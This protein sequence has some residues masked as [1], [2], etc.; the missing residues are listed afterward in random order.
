MPFGQIPFVFLSREKFYFLARLY[1]PKTKCTFKTRNNYANQFK[2]NSNLAV[3]KVL[4]HRPPAKLKDIFPSHLHFE[5][6]VSLSFDAIKAASTYL[7][8]LKLVNNYNY[9]STPFLRRAIHRYGQ[10]FKLAQR[11]YEKYGL[12]HL[13]SLVPT[14]D[15][16]FIWATHMIHPHQY[17]QWRKQFFDGSEGKK[18]AINTWFSN[19]TMRIQQHAASDIHVNK[20]KERYEFT[21]REWEKMYDDNYLLSNSISN[22][23]DSFLAVY[24]QGT[25]DLSEETGL[26]LLEA[27]KRHLR[28][29]KRTLNLKFINNSFLEQ[30]TERYKNFLLMAK[31]YNGLL[32]PTLDIDII[33]HTHMLSPIDYFPDCERIAGR[34]LNHNDELP[35]D[36]LTDHFQKTEE[37][38]IRNYSSPYRRTAPKK[39]EKTNYVGSACA[40][41]GFGDAYFH[42]QLGHNKVESQIMEQM[43]NNNDNDIIDNETDRDLIDNDS[44]GG[45]F[46][47]SWGDSDAGSGDSG[48]SCSSCGGD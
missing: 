15:I 39:K 41:C 25:K 13:S 24:V 7:E 46:S 5:K 31:D 34:V 19:Q 32:V 12:D 16:S 9:T 26:D 23:L 11:I 28:F 45:A 4:P 22:E 18:L 43:E 30:A 20:W 38:W 1:V 6:D 27:S 37:R 47:F 42:Q 3:M 35:S 2:Q 14:R 36:E 48:S 21:A 33:W 40:S 17:R 10:Y 29:A 44:D 8:F